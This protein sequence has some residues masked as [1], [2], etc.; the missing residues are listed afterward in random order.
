[1]TGFDAFLIVFKDIGVRTNEL[2]V[3][4]PN[5]TSRALNLNLINC[6][7]DSIRMIN[8]IDQDIVAL[9]TRRD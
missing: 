6:V 3:L 9:E 8:L 5:P 7:E 1:M 2:S 4:F